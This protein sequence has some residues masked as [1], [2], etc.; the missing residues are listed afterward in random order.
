M[1]LMVM[2]S[3]KDIEVGMAV[4]SIPVGMRHLGC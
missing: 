3:M 1:L 2:V 4:I